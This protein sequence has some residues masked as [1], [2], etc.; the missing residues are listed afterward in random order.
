MID[1]VDHPTKVTGRRVLAYLIDVVPSFVLFVLAV[2]AFGE[3][4]P[5]GTVPLSGVNATWS[6]GGTQY[7]AEGGAAGK[8]FLTC[9]LY[10]VA[11][12]V[13]LQGLAGASIGKM[14][15]GIRVVRPDGR[16]CGVGKALVRWL[17]L[18][19]DAFPFFAPLVG[20]V[21]VLSTNGNRRLGDMAAGT[22]VVRAAAAGQPVVLP[23]A[24]GHGHGY[25][26]PPPV[27]DARWDAARG[28]WLR[29]DGSAWTQLDPATGR[30]FQLQ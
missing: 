20:F 13:V 21:L 2:Q 3:E 22:Y 1:A 29:W 4:V 28:A 6:W 18:I 19:V 11:N 8:V 24:G 15:T 10:L 12:L 27:P 14:A 16:P 7:L 25:P 5:P 9:T 26:P 17:V 30:W 23:G